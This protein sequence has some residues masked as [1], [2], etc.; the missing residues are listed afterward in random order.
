M[1]HPPLPLAEGR[2]LNEPYKRGTPQPTTSVSNSDLLTTIMPCYSDQE[3]A[4]AAPQKECCAEK[5]CCK[6]EGEEECKCTD[7]KCCSGEEAEAPKEESA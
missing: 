4:P 2:S 3:P 6:H 1:E 7:C 5:E